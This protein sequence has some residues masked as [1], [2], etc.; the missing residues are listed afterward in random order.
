MLLFSEILLSVLT[1]VSNPN[2][3]RLWDPDG[4]GK[5]FP[6]AFS[7]NFLHCIDLSLKEQ[8]F[9]A[10]I[11]HIVLMMYYMISVHGQ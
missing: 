7:N 6:G 1:K 5:H 10:A 9:E 11:I 4:Q 3:I 8:N 2:L